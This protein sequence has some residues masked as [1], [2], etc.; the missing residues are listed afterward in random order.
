MKM[1]RNKISR[2]PISVPLWTHALPPDSTTAHLSHQGSVWRLELMLALIR[3]LEAAAAKSAVLT[4]SAVGR[5][6]LARLP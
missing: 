5:W 6:E 1:T 3:H 4:V 2:T